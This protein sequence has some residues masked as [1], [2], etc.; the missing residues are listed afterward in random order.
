MVVCE[1]QNKADT[2]GKHTVYKIKGRDHLGEFEIF[3]RFKQFDLL[4]RTFTIRFLGL[5]VPPIPE[6]KAVGKTEAFF[7]EERMFYLNRFVEDLCHLPYLYESQ[8][9]AIFL[10]PPGDF[11]LCIASLP[12]LTTETMLARLREI[13]PL[14]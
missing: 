7:V 4:R 13:V 2:I 5:Y 8:E 3:R 12:P 11:D 1:P 9:F 14:N 10:R 6:K